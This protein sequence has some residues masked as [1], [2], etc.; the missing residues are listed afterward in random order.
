VSLGFV[1]RG[2]RGGVPEEN[3]PYEHPDNGYDHDEPQDYPENTA[4]QG[5]FILFIHLRSY[6]QAY[7]INIIVYFGKLSK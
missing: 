4:E 1:W 6:L 7:V 2:N 3:Q 5:Y